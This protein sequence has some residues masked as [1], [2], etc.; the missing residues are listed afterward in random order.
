MEDTIFG[1]ITYKSNPDGS[2][3][4]KVWKTLNIKNLKERVDKLASKE[5]FII[6]MGLSGEDVDKMAKEK[7]I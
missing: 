5:Q 7:I 4:P 2:L 6:F 3:S 1:I